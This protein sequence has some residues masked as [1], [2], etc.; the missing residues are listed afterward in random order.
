ML[1]RQF[2][3][4]VVRG[5]R[6]SGRRSDPDEGFRVLV[7]CLDPVAQVFLQGLDVA[8]IGALQEVSGGFGEE[9]FDLVDP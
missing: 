7:P 4:V 1:R 8:V 2:V 6:G 3:V 5:I 9:P